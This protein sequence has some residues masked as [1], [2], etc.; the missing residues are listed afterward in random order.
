[1]SSI[2]TC[3]HLCI[4][5][6]F[7]NGCVA[8]ENA[9]Q[10]V[11]PQSDHSKLDRLLFDRDRW[12]ALVNQF[13]NWI[14][15]SEKLVNSFA[16]FVASVVTGVATFAVKELFFTEIAASDAKLG[17]Q[18]VTWSVWRAAMSTNAAQQPLTKNGF[19]R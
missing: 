18:R 6:H 2:T 12:R 16:S 9:A 13:T 4:S 11:L 17:Q 5:Q 10:T 15:H 8:C 14:C 19:Q 7:L 1:M 3:T